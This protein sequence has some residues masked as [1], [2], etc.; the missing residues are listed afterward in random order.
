MPTILD[1]WANKYLTAPCQ[2]L[3]PPSTVVPSVKIDPEICDELQQNLLTLADH[4]VH[5]RGPTG[6][7]LVVDVA[8]PV[9]SQEELDAFNI[10]DLS[11][12]IQFQKTKMKLVSNLCC[13]VQ[14]SLAIDAGAVQI[15]SGLIQRWVH[16]ESYN[17]VVP[18]EQGP[19][20]ASHIVLVLAVDLL[21]PAQHSQPHPKFVTYL[22]KL[23]NCWSHD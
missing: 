3:Q 23:P 22:A 12:L 13:K 17:K 7:V 5:H 20:Q 10:A 21:L 14:G 15:Q 1:L 18:L 6:D 11:N 19:H 9:V 8:K 4:G 2:L 16:Q